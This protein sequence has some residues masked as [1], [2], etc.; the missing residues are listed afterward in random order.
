M[1]FIDIQL[2]L[3]FG[4][5]LCI[6]QDVI[7]MRTGPAFYFLALVSS[8]PSLTTPRCRKLI[9]SLVTAS[10]IFETMPI[11]LPSR[12]NTLL[13]FFQSV[14]A[15]DP[16]EKRCCPCPIGVITPQN[17]PY[18]FTRCVNRNFKFL[19]FHECSIFFI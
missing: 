13:P 4:F 8:I 12:N 5:S 16:S 10:S 14:T 3:Q 17:I 7:L 6:F 1:F 9:Y 15:C 18:F 11:P 2:N 19:L